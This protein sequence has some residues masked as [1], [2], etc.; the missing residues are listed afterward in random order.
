MKCKRV[1]LLLLIAALCTACLHASAYQEATLRPGMEGDE[2]TRLQTA[3]IQQGYLSGTADG[4][5]GVNTENAVRAF[6]RKHKIKADGLA[7][8]KTQSLLY[9]GSGREQEKSGSQQA[10]DS[11]KNSASA[12][13]QSVTLRYGDEGENVRKLQSSLIS[14]GYLSGTADGQY[15]RQT[16]SAVYRFQKDHQLT[17]DGV[18]GAK[19]QSLLYAGSG[20]EQEKSGSNQASGSGKNSASAE[21]QSVTMRYGDEGENVRELQSSL[22]SLGYLSGTADGK[23]GKQTQSAVY[24]FQKDHQLTTDG[25]AGAKTQ[26]VL[27]TAVKNPVSGSSRPAAAEPAAAAAA[28]DKSDIKLL[29]WYDD[30]KPSLKAKQT[31]LIYDPATGL[32]WHLRVYSRGRHCDAEPLTLADTQTMVQA[33]GGKNTWNQKGVYVRLPSGTWTVGATHDMPHL[34]GTIDDNDFNG[35]L[36][37]HFLRNMEECEKYDPNYGVSNQRTIRELWKKLTGE[38]VDI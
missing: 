36:C 27:S 38:T 10:A 24:R 20:K 19:T 11:G 9:A 29:H 30:I 33:F 26:D 32:S 14:L 22:I 23:Y 25:V 35:H 18:A 34:S 6:Q 5:Y 15:G 21:S 7:G 28:P 12:E 16:Q 3:L 17:T 31:L 8:A 13:S 37:V 4:I 1:C 2:V